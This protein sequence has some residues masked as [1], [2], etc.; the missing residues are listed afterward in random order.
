M[1]QK[2]FFSYSG[3]EHCYPQAARLGGQDL[4]TG[5]AQAARGFNAEEAGSQRGHMTHP[6]T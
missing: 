3:H 6:V 2:C 4:G 1:A 5:W